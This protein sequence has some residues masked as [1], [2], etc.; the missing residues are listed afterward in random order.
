VRQ[1]QPINSALGKR[2]CH[3]HTR[4]DNRGRL[5]SVSQSADGQTRTV[6]YTY[7]QSQNGGASSGRLTAITD[8]L[9][10]TTTFTYDPNL[11]GRVVQQTFPNGRFIEFQYDANGN[12]TGVTPPQKPVHL[13][14]F[15]AVDLL[16]QYTP[17]PA[18]DTGNNFTTYEYNLNQQ[19]T[20]ITRP[21]G[22]QIAYV[23]DPQIGWLDH[24]EL[25]LGERIS[26][27][28]VQAGCGC[29]G[30]GQP[31]DVTFSAAD[32][33]ST[34]HY[35]Y[36]GSLV[37][38]MTW[39]GP[40]TGSVTASYDNFFRVNSLSVND[41]NPVNFSYDDDGLLVQAGALTLARDPLTRI[42]LEKKL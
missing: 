3:C 40:V 33:T 18:L 37:T 36:D 15:N 16:S 12:L 30:A 14:E 22:L 21:D 27:T 13:F 32:Y 11:S 20:R 9:N 8:S 24:V 1:S 25:P 6:T 10:R 35:D 38:G 41:V 2:S 7:D 19:L 42:F 17:P 29:S 26:Y 31:S 23:Y 28:Y 5:I 34:I 39:S 4:Y